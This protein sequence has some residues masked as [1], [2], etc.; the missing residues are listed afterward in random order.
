M[1]PMHAL[2]KAA[3]RQEQNQHR[4]DEIEMLLDGKDQNAEV[5]QRVA[6]F[7]SPSS[8]ILMLVQ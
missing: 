5:E 8:T 1:I 7:Q 3:C 4:P 6:N 2:T